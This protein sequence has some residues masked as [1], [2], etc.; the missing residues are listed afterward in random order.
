[1]AAARRMLDRA[2]CVLRGIIGGSVGHQQRRG[3]QSCGSPFLPLRSRLWQSPVLPDRQATGDHPCREEIWRSVN[4]TRG[5]PAASPKAV[6]GFLAKK[7]RFQAGPFFFGAPRSARHMLVA[8]PH[9]PLS[10][11]VLALRGSGMEGEGV[12]LVECLKAREK[13]GEKK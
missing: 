9:R 3:T 8:R 13:E 4:R 5:A 1:M 12:S 7:A 6:E 2:P 11:D 10:S